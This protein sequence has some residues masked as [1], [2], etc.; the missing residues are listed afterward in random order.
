M[1]A[2]IRAT[3]SPRGEGGTAPAPT[4]TRYRVSCGS[5]CVGCGDRIRQTFATLDG[6][7]NLCQRVEDGTGCPHY[8]SPVR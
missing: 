1:T 8:V 2:T 4:T 3:L 5:G 6:A 7:Y